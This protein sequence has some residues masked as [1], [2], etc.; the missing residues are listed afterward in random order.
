MR[1]ELRTKTELVVV[2]NGLVIAAAL[3]VAPGI[4]VLVTE[5]RAGTGEQ[6]RR[7]EGDRH[8][9]EEAAEAWFLV[10]H[11]VRD[12]RAALRDCG[13]RRAAALSGGLSCQQQFVGPGGEIA[14]VGAAVALRPSEGD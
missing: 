8:D 10:P 5:P 14:R 3:A 11:H 7:T 12:G 4:S 13:Y 6:E 1:H 2:T 9:D